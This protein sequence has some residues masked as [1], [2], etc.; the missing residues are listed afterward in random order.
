MYDI[1][2]RQVGMLLNDDLLTPGSYRYIWDAAH[3]PSG[4]YFYQIIA[5][6]VNGNVKTIIFREVRKLLLVK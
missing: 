3:L 6:S 2:G 1:L 5:A 4:V